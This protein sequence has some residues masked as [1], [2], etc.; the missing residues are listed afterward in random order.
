MRALEAELVGPYA[1][2]EELDRA[3]SRTYLT[4]FLVSAASFDREQASATGEEPDRQCA[5]PRAVL[6]PRTSSR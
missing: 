2:Q 5:R 4:G 6:A 1:E 3:P